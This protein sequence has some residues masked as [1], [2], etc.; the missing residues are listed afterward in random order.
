[1]YKLIPV[2]K[3]IEVVKLIF[4]L[5]INKKGFPSVATHLCSHHYK[6]KNGGEF[7]QGTVEQ[8]IKNP[9]YTFAD[10]KIYDYLKILVQ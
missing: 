7:S 9:V 5:Y 3:E 2:P 10:K 8:I 6:G 1:M 4:D